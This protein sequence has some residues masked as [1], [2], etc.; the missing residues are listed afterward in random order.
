M[1]L[2]NLRR[3]IRNFLIILS[4]ILIPNTLIAS[5]FSSVKV[6]QLNF[7]DSSLGSDSSDYTLELV[8]SKDQQCF[9]VK[10]IDYDKSLMVQ[11]NKEIKIY[12]EHEIIENC[13]EEPEASVERVYLGTLPSGEYLVNVYEND[14]L[15]VSKK[16]YFPSNQ[17]VQSEKIVSQ[18]IMLIEN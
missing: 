10:A 11:I 8:R 12:V 17:S 5:V 2:R 13:L 4:G 14:K 16:L 15:T 7:L 1:T 18:P 3:K 6:S 9:N